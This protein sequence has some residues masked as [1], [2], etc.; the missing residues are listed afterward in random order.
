M[1]LVDPALRGRRVEVPHRLA[2]GL[3]RLPCNPDAHPRDPG[4]CRW[5][6]DQVRLRREDARGAVRT[7]LALDRGERVGELREQRLGLAVTRVSGRQERSRVLEMRVGKG[8][9]LEPAHR[10]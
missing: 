1:A 10:T 2:V 4:N 9:E 3:D 5:R 8:H 6:C 7:P